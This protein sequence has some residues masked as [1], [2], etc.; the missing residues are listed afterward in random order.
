MVVD[1]GIGFLLKIILGNYFGA[2]GLGAYSMVLVIYLIAATLGGIGIP[3]ALVKYVAEYKTKK[4]K[5]YNFVSCGVIN[6]LILGIILTGIIFVL[7]DFIESIF[8]I[9]VK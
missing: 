9:P 4:S 5:L 2:P 6:S 7:S 1:L 3:A 8:N